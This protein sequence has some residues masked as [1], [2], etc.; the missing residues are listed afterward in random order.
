MISEARDLSQ[1]SGDNPTKWIQRHFN[2]LYEIAESG[3]AQLLV[4]TIVNGVRPLV[5]KG[6]SDKNF[7]TLKFNLE[8]SLRRGKS[9]MQIY[10][11]YINNYH[12]RGSGLGMENNCQVAIASMITEDIEPVQLTQYQLFL[13]NLVESIMPDYHVSLLNG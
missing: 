2:E 1:T 5:G 7:R 8:D 11:G 3:D 10:T 9:A 6:F 4:Q 13:K 12:L